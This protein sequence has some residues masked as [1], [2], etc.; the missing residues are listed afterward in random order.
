MAANVEIKA[1]VADPAALRERA[2]ALADWP[3]QRL[4]QTDTFFT[5]P[6]GRL[7]LRE[8]GDGTAE[9]IQ[10]ERPDADGPKLSRYRRLDVPDPAGLKAALADAL[11]VRAVVVKHRDVLMAG[12]TRI[13][14]DRVEGLGDFMELEVVLAEGEDL[15]AG[16]AEARD[17]MTRLGIAAT[18]LVTGAYVDLLEAVEPAPGGMRDARR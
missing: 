11:G 1:R 16:E 9:L 5:V 17:L 18:D 13:H 4:E 6:T 7:K 3:A 2:V 14:L 15:A 10:Y 8:F 12:R